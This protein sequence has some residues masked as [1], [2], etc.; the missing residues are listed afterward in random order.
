VTGYRDLLSF[1]PFQAVFTE[2]RSAVVIHI[3]DLERRVLDP[4]TPLDVVERLR[5]E[6]A[7]VLKVLEIVQ[8][9][10]QHEEQEQ[11]KPVPVG[12]QRL[13]DTLLPRTL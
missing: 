12:K 8:A 13:A 6:R 7:G 2:A 10:A 5:S 9:M 3:K 4:G 1:P 11:S